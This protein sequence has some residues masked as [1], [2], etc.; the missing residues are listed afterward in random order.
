MWQE[1]KHYMVETLFS[2]IQ[3]SYCPSHYTSPVH[4]TRL[5]IQRMDSTLE[6]CIY[7][8]QEPLWCCRQGSLEHTSSES[9]QF[10]AQDYASKVDNSCHFPRPCPM[11]NDLGMKH[12]LMLYVCT[13]K[14]NHAH[15]YTAYCMDH[16]VYKE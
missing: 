1:E 12:V 3:C 16:N 13:R 9:P 8:V 10:P 2:I 11:S 5:H 4:C 6:K 15:S 14:Q 7:R